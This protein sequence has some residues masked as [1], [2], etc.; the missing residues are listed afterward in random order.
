MK[1]IVFY[2]SKYGN[3]E[4]ISLAIA[5]GLKAGGVG[6]VLVMKL[7]TADEEDF[8][9]RQL[10]VVGSPTRWGSATFGLRTLLKNA[11]NYE[12]KDKKAAVFDTRFENMHRGAAEKLKVIF[13]RSSIGLVLSPESFRVMTI[14]GPLAEGE[15]ARAEEFGK[16][17]AEKVR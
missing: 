1:A 16:Q 6:D 5:R 11:I 12:G 17:I 10:W 4:T 2:D 3:T 15:E 9:D 13:E 14:K 7:K 8:K